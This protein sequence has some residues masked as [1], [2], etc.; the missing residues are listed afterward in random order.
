LRPGGYLLL[1]PTDA[2][3]DPSIYDVRW[4]GDAVGYALNSSDE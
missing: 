2:P 1:G 3:A 4:G